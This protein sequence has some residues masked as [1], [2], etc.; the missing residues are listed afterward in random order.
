ML[1][2]QRQIFRTSFFRN[3]LTREYKQVIQASATEALHT[4][5][6]MA[7]VVAN[8]ALAPRL[9]GASARSSGSLGA[10]KGREI[11]GSLRQFLR[12]SLKTG[13]ARG[14]SSRNVHLSVPRSSIATAPEVQR[15]RDS[16]WS[17][18][19]SKSNHM[20]NTQADFFLTALSAP[21]VN[22]PNVDISRHVRSRKPD[23]A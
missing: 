4:R 17:S 18:T 6:N 1:A 10:S 13:A 9:T 22:C 2:A 12:A 20:S 14:L 8:S 11:F 23:A 3:S 5:T 19:N 15:G 7:G 16:T 21:V